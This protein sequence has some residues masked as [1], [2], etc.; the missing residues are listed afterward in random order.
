MIVS[1]LAICALAYGV[2]LLFFLTGFA[3]GRRSD[4]SAAAAPRVTVIVPARNEVDTIERC[5][6]SLAACSYPADRLEIL[7]VDD[8]STDGTDRVLDALAMHHPMI[9]PVHRISTDYHPNLRGKPG[10]LQHGIDRASGEIILMTDADCRV[11]PTWISTM[12]APFVDDRVG[13]VCSITSVETSG[14]FGSIQDVEWTFSQSMARAGLQHGMPLGCYGNNI[15][16]RRS[17]FDA[18]GGYEAIPFSITE[19]LALLQVAHDAGWKISYL[20]QHE[21]S[22]VTLPCATMAEYISQR[23]RWVRGGTALGWRA[24]LFV[25]TSVL[26]WLGIVTAGALH[27]WTWFTL[28]VGMRIVGDATLVTWALLRLRRRSTIPWVGPSVAMLMLTELALPF[29]LLRRDVVWKGQIF[30]H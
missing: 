17:M 1:L 9:T 7:I 11:A 16:L 25:V 10:A 3:R 24:T 23:Q 29:L 6:Q 26:L 28:M 30:R 2:R 18:L 27:M 8:R 20:C 4:P 12:V 5:I 21:S 14:P 22:V 19:D 15:A 13:M